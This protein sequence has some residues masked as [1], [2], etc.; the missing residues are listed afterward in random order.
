MCLAI[1]A[2]IV[3]LQGDSALVDAMGNSFRAKTTLLAGVKIG[4]IVLV[5]A[6]FAISKVDEKDAR[7]T[8]QLIEQMEK[9]SQTHDEITG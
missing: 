1:P 8:W 2:K 3:E 9:L 6:G 5:H 4:D 7:L